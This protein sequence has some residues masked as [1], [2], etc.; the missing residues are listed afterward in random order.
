MKRGLFTPGKR[1]RVV[2]LSGSSAAPATD[3]VQIFDN[4]A[5]DSAPTSELLTVSE[6]AKFFKVSESTIR[7]L[8]AERRIAFYPVRRGIRFT[9]QDLRSYLEKNRVES[10]G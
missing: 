10:I 7:R 9:K 8:Q 6:A 1:A 5:V 3:P 2:E 4:P